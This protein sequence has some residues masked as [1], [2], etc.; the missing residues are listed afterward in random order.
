MSGGGAAE[1][2][3]PLAGCERTT[4]E[5]SPKSATQPLRAAV[6]E[7]RSS[8]PRRPI[9][10]D[11]AAVMAWRALYGG[12]GAAGAT[13]CIWVFATARMATTI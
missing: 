2:L 10:A 13:G 4:V 9:T 12:N 11:A 6:P 1:A 8:E 7:G 3:P 5:A